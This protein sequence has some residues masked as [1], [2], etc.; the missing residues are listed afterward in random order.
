LP[1]PADGDVDDDA[2]WVTPATLAAALAR[3]FGA[4]PGG[5]RAPAAPA[6]PA[7]APVACA[8][9][10]Y[11]VQNV[12]LGMGLGVLG[13]GG[14]V[15]RRVKAFVLKCDAC[16]DV[17]R[18]TA[19]LFCPRCGNATLARMG[20]TVDAAGREHFHVKRD[21]VVST[22]GARFALPRQAGGR[23]PGLLLR[24][25][26]LLTGAWRAKVRAARREEAAVA[27]AVGGDAAGEGGAE[28]AAGS[29]WAV[30]G[31]SG[32]VAG[33]GRRNLNA[34]RGRERR[35]KKKRQVAQAFG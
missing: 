17:V 8:T 31:A 25:D 24:E 15:V 29:W 5:S 32:V 23:D 33:V 26:Q 1:A 34:E 21:R 2:G 30:R 28:P 19:R 10:D 11:T 7:S 12:L 27:R 35:G 9:V 14:R 3:G 13:V 6:P 22:R 20:V 4:A 16:F 18:D